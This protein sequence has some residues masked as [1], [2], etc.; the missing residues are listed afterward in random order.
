MKHPRILGI[1][2][3]ILLAAMGT[4]ANAAGPDDYWPTWR[5]PTATGTA[6]QGNPPLT[7]GES[8]NIKWKVEIPGRG[9]SSPVVWGDK[10]FLL[11]AIDTGQAPAPGS[12][13]APTP[14]AAPG[15]RKGLSTSA[16]KTLHKFDLVCVDRATGKI[17]WEKTAIEAVPHEGHQP[18]TTF[19]SYS[20]VTD[21]KYVWASFGSRGLYCYDLEGNLKWSQPLIT[22]KTVM[23]FGEGS[24]PALAGDA[25]IVVCD[26]E[27]DSAIFAFNKV[28]GEQLWRRDRDERTSWATP[29]VAEVDG[30][31]QV[32]TSATKLIRSYDAA[33]GDL[34]WQC[35]GQVRNVI[36]SPVLGFGMVFCT[37]GYQGSSLQAIK[38]AGSRGDISGTDAIAWQ[39]NK[40]TPYVASPLLY[41]DRIYVFSVLTPKLSCYEA[42]TGKP[43]FTEQTLTG[44]N[45]VYASPIGAADRVYCCGRNGVT[46][47]IRNADIFEILATNKLDDGLDASPAVVGEELYLRGNQSLY[48]IAR[49]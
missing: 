49:K 31:I 23:S 35:S 34:I 33:S 11:T 26:H 14:A 10:I 1:T 18:T 7:W 22:M 15:G 9:H 13:P 5:G 25:V 41:G 46:V 32:I 39:V 40:G 48:C 45:Q 4:Q 38:L 29:A 27:G 44:I 8:E 2:V 19:A 3:V 24:S 21:G 43:L 16:P 37:S 6:P 47:V 12:Q 36:P 20:P 17:R 42:R 30:R 28:T